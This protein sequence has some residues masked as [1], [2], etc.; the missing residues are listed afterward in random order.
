[1]AQTENHTRFY[2]FQYNMATEGKAERH[3]TIE[4]VDGKAVYT[5]NVELD[6]ASKVFFDTVV[7]QFNLNFV[8]QIIDRLKNKLDK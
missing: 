1:M 3:C 4:I 2:I 8:E 5:G 7:G 6:E